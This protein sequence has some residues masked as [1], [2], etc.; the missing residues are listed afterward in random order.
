MRFLSDNYIYILF[1]KRKVEF[2]N[3]EWIYDT[4][5]IGVFSNK[6]KAL[7]TIEKYKNIDGFKDYPYDFIIDKIEIDFDDYFFEVE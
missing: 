4:K 2:Y 6:N 1:H 7:Q 3:S 5:L